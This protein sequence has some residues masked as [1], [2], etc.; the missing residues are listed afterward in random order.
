MSNHRFKKKK[1]TVSVSKKKKKKKKKKSF[2]SGKKKSR[3]NDAKIYLMGVHIKRKTQE[4]PIEHQ[5]S[6]CQIP[7]QATKKSHK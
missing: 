6:L 4:W 2:I 5:T 7:G 3:E 1:K